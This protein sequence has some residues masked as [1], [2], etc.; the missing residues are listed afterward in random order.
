MRPDG[1]EVRRN[2]IDLRAGVVAAAPHVPPKIPMNLI[3]SVLNTLFIKF[4]GRH[5]A[6]HEVWRNRL[7]LSDGVVAATPG[8]PLGAPT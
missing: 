8:Y 4:L 5:P 2:L 1:H 6:G 7:Y 3:Y